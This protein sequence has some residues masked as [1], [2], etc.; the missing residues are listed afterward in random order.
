MFKSFD[1]IL[2]GIYSLISSMMCAIHVTPSTT[3]R[4]PDARLDIAYSSLE[5]GNVKSF[6][7][8][9]CI[10][11]CM[12]IHT[13]AVRVWDLNIINPENEQIRD[14]KGHESTISVLKLAKLPRGDDT[15]IDNCSCDDFERSSSRST[16]THRPIEYET[17]SIPPVNDQSISQE[18]TKSESR[19]T[20]AYIP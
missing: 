19:N 14:E 6:F 3:T 12:F 13:S 10:Y 8:D 16:S 5:Y 7:L 4:V 2:C 18:L 9:V 20:E 1:T 11:N 15:E 17:S